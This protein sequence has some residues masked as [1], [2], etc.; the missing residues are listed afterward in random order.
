MVKQRRHYQTKP[1]FYYNFQ[2]DF[3]RKIVNKSLYLNH[4][5]LSWIRL[6]FIQK[7]NNNK[8][9]KRFFISHAKLA[10]PIGYSTSVPRKTF[11][12][13]RFSCIKYLDSLTV[14]VFLK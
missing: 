12:L 10:C 1:I 4:K 6:S 3:L 11:L 14:G 7:Q 8:S 5:Q 2:K 13:S 9:D